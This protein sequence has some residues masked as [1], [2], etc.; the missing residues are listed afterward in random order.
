[1][2]ILKNI[3][4][5]LLVLFFIPSL[6]SA[7]HDKS[8]AK[9]KIKWLSLEQAIKLNKKNPKK[10][11]IDVYTDWC[12]YCKKMDRETF[13]NSEVAKEINKNYYAV[14]FNAEQKEPI[15]FKGKKYDY[16]KNGSRGVHSL[17]ASLLQNKLSYPSMVYLTEDLELI[18][19]VPGYL[20]PSQILPI[21][22][23]FGNDFYQK[24]TWKEFMNTY[25]ET[26][27]SKQ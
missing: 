25:K 19:P 11:L 18:Q 7:E 20:T 27:K 13:T 9:K 5:L 10:I 6:A 2:T 22:S 4:Y 23:F 8:D 17:A 1:M 3:A 12:G 21:L 26:T 15:T 16:I 14:K 24:K